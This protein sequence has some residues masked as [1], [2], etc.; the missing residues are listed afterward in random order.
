MD[1]EKFTLEYFEDWVYDQP[2][3]TGY[4]FSDGSSCPFSLFLSQLYGVTI[5]SNFDYDGYNVVY[6]NPKEP[7]KTYY[8]PAFAVFICAA[9]KSRHSYVTIKQ[10]KAV[11]NA[12]I[13]YNNLTPEQKEEFIYF[14]KF[15]NAENVVIK[16][17]YQIT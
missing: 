16:K 17:N 1:T 4:N 3:T 9:I 7:R 14:G 2:E 12:Y 5:H 11:I 10:I 8:F 15:A 13:K 6:Y